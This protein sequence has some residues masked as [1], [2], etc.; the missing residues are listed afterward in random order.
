MQIL[1]SLLLKR[2]TV[3]E[4]EGSEE[5]KNT[6]ESNKDK[7]KA[8]KDFESEVISTPKSENEK[9]EN[10][11]TSQKAASKYIIEDGKIIIPFIKSNSCLSYCQALINNQAFL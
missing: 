2:H 4:N 10:E 3:N 11:N 6:V 9:E 7:I 1:A 8:E 5:V